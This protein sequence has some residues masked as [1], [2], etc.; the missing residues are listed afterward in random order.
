DRR[1]TQDGDA[2]AWNHDVAV[3]RLVAA[4]DGGVRQ[5]ARE[6]DHD[7]F[8]RDDLDLDVE[9][10][11]DE[12][13]PGARR[14]DHRLAADGGLFAGHRVASHHP[15]DPVAIAAKADDLGVGS[16]LRSAAPR[17]LDVAD[18]E[19]EGVQMAVLGN[20]ED[21]PHLRRQRRLA[22]TRLLERN[23]LAGDPGFAASVDESR[24][25]GF[26]LFGHRHEVTAGVL[27][28]GARDATKDATLLDA[29][30]GGGAVLA[31]KT[32]PDG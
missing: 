23:A 20:P 28:C 8:D 18:H 3:A 29:L 10:P 24:L 15:G 7:T 31:R 25:P 12:A 9:Q 1:R 6:D 19:V 32:S 2:Q 5:A 11:G 22:A 14:I 27:D 13:R 30:D 21:G 16:D 26:V 17:G 4:V